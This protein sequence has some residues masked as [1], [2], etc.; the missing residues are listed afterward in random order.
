MFCSKLFKHEISA[1]CYLVFKP[2]PG[3]P[4][5]LTEDSSAPSQLGVEGGIRGDAA[6]RE[7]S[8]I[9]SQ[10]DCGASGT[11]ASAMRGGQRTRAATARR[12]RTPHPGG[13]SRAQN[14]ACRARLGGLAAGHGGAPQLPAPS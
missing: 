1:I 11:V 13:L 2:D 12:G 10:R 6:G 7:R 14:P 4:P 9:A 8:A 5:K 3:L